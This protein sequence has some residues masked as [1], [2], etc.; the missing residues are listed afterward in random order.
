MLVFISTITSETGLWG[1]PVHV[2]EGK[3]ITGPYYYTGV[4]LA[5]NLDAD[6]VMLEYV[7]P[8]QCNASTINLIVQYY[9]G[10]VNPATPTS[11]L[12]TDYGGYQA[13]M[14]WVLT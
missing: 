5:E 13:S 12:T 2:Y 3:T 9:L 7:V 14:D 4:S 6:H 1:G 8:I 10:S 11:L